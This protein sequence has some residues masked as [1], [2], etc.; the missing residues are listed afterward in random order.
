[1]PSP[2]DTPDELPPAVRYYLKGHSSTQARWSVLLGDTR[3]YAPE[4]AQLHESILGDFLAGSATAAEPLV[5][6]VA[7]GPA[8]G[9]STLLEE[10]DVPPNAVRL[11]PDRIK[12]HLP[13][14]VALGAIKFAGA[15][16]LV[17]EESSDIAR[18]ILDQTLRDKRNVIFDTVGDSE[19]GKF[20]G[21][22]E[23]FSNAGYEIDVVYADVAVELALERAAQR[24]ASAWSQ[25][26]WSGHCIAKSQRGSKR[27]RFSRSS[28]PCASTRRKME[29]L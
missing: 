23:D 16:S 1:M 6:V 17:H 20:V 11:D 7:G 28:D 2:E 13:E 18:L 19:P 22:L 21:K 4:R 3:Y 24:S 25:R 27:L 10:L 14:Y 8:S 15:A 26:M 5:L 9:K 12:E 29:S